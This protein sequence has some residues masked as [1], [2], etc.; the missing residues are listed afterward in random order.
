[1]HKGKL[2]GNTK[3]SLGVD[4]G[5]NFGIC[6]ITGEDIY[7]MYG[8]LLQQTHHIEYANVAFELLTNLVWTNEQTDPVYVIEG[9]AFNKT[10]GQVNLAE[11]RTGFYLSLRHLGEIHTPPP[12]TV[13]KAVFG[14]G[15]I[16]PMDIWPLL[17][18]NCAD[19]LSLALYGLYQ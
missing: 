8:S 14:S 16:Q 7:A 9:P 6:F 17:N 15:T 3:C 11:V 1:M 5:V 19:A 4:P 10:F 12:M 13:R 18:H 2:P